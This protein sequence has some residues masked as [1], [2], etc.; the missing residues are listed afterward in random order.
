MDCR[1]G[2][3]V[4]AQ[5]CTVGARGRVVLSYSKREGLILANTLILRVL[6]PFDDQSHHCCHEYTGL[7]T[8]LVNL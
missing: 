2:R 7:S 3:R 5:A 6:Q 1:E 4:Q 8:T